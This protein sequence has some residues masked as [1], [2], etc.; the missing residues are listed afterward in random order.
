VPGFLGA[1][2]QERESAEGP[3]A[4]GLELLALGKDCVRRAVKL[5]SLN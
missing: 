3:V 5:R 4:F 1:E 2:D